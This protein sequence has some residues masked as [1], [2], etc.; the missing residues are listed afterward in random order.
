MFPTF[1]S[2]VAAL[3]GQRVFGYEDLNNRDELRQH[4]RMAVLAGKLKAEC[5]HC[6]PLASKSKL[7]RLELSREIATRTRSATVG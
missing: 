7:N 2:T 4:P 3:T 1:S 6:A 5:G